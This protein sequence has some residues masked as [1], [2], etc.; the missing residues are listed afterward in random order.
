MLELLCTVIPIYQRAGVE[1]L[2]GGADT[3]IIE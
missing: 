3:F 2:A 1:G